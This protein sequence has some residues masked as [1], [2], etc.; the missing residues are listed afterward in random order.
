MGRVVSMCESLLNT[1]VSDL[2]TGKHHSDTTTFA[3]GQLR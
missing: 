3:G 1:E 2:D